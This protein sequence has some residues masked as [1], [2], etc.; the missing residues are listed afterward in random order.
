MIF[1]CAHCSDSQNANESNSGSI[2]DVYGHWL[3]GHTD[4]IDDQNVQ[5]FWFYVTNNF[6]CSHCDVV[7]NYQQM[8]THYFDKHSDQSFAIV[9]ET[10][11]KKCGLC[12]HFGD[13]MATHFAR[14]HDGLLQSEK[15]FNPARLS[16]GV[17]GKLM[18]ID[19]HKKRQCGGCNIIL[20]TQH[21]M[22]VHQSTEHHGETNSNEYFDGQ[23]AYVL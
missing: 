9:T 18:S 3:S 4:P 21:E 2:E 5:P 19:I 6:A 17:L 16:V 15:L 7:C 11:R 10:D 1:F 23:S 14:E 20:E 8:I 22:D 13:D 12:Q